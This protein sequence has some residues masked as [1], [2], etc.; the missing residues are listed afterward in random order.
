MFSTTAPMRR[1]R[2]REAL[3]HVTSPRPP[4]RLALA[5]VICS[6]L[7][8]LTGP[9]FGQHYA[10][11]IVAPTAPS[12]RL[13]A[14][15][16]DLASTLEQMTGVPFKRQR[17]SSSERAAV[18]AGIVVADA[19]A[20]EVPGSVRQRLGEQGPESFVIRS[21]NDD[22]LW[23]VANHELGLSHG[24]YFYLE[25]L[26]A[27]WYFPNPKWELIPERDS[28][29]LKIDRLISPS[30]I[31][32]DFFGSGGFGPPIPFDAEPAV[33]ERWK[34][35]KRRNRFGEQIRMHGHVGHG[36]S[37]R[38]KEA[39][40]A[41]PEYRPMIDGERIAYKDGI[42]F[43]MSNPDALDLF[44]KDRLRALERVVEAEDRRPGLP[45][46]GI[47]PSDGGGHC[48]CPD[49]QA[50]G[51]GSISDRVFHMANVVARRAAERFPGSR[52]SLY[53]Y[54]DHAA[55]P[56]I[57]LEP[58]VH[59]WVI[60]YA[61]Q[62]TGL[63]GDD[64]L[65]A[66]GRRAS[67][68]SLYDYWSI[69]D[70]N[71]ELPTFDFR[72]HPA[73]RL[74]FWHNNGVRALKFE[75]TYGAGAMGL[76]LHVASRLM[77]DIDRD[78][79]QVLEAFYDRAF[80]DAAEPMRRMLERWRQDFL[81]SDHELAMSFRDLRRAYDRSTGEPAV[82]ARVGDYVRYVQ[83]L[84]RWHEYRSADNGSERRMERARRLIRLLWRIYPSTMVHSYRMYRLIAYRFEPDSDLRQ[85]LHPARPDDPAWDKLTTPAESE[86]A[87]W[88]EAGCAEY[89]PKS[90]RR[91]HYSDRLRPIKPD[92]KPTGEFTDRIRM[93][94]TVTLRA[95]VKAGVTAVPLKIMVRDH[96]G[97][98]NRVTAY[99]PAE[100]QIFDRSLPA[101]G[102]WRTLRI[103][104]PKP[105]EYRIRIF[106]QKTQFRL[107]LPAGIP[108]SFSRH[109]ATQLSPH[110]YFY[111]PRDL[112]TLAMYMPSA[113]VVRVH[114]ADGE[115]VHEG[116]KRM[117]ILPVPDDQ[118]G[119]V[120]SFS[121]RKSWKTARMLN[122][123][124]WFSL[125]RDTLLVPEDAR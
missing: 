16:A 31:S 6:L 57:E 30:F 60:P 70:W 79:E 52:V 45:T 108:V 109:V 37:R 29:T 39:L 83:Y 104:T 15:L 113:S 76:G 32:R 73:E 10:Q 43:C 110:V 97:R 40:Q 22:R 77:W 80:G 89:E 68:L 121:N 42:K 51:N 86:L 55:P 23:I 49:C 47:E 119:R 14:A 101:D 8:V 63:S 85:Y 27:R 84:R 100:E 17:A 98:A 105:G 53:A 67:K 120:W 12:D 95:H 111:V 114:N 81:L 5:P 2:L 118:A 48:Q 36:F 66:W 82:R 46:V 69:P 25:R 99:S 115:T 112:D 54:N 1:T 11:R 13:E 71:K 26:G 91:R 124:Q 4:R 107:R 20:A 38:A 19:R 35:W 61:F 117:I 78:H 65:R 96:P 106:D 62:R 18:E 116:R 93:A 102:E 64:L 59:V 94:G 56:S 41:H 123:P 74:R 90:F 9:A 58:N 50:I 88:I 7:L 44:A 75:S 33:R 103:A 21:V 72:E 122:A 28:V 34:Q 24:I 92:L 87:E 125:N 3:A